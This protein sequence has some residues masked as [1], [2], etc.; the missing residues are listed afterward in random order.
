VVKSY[1]GRGEKTIMEQMICQQLHIDGIDEL[2]DKVYNPTLTKP[3]IA[4]MSLLCFEA[5][6]KGDSVAGKILAQ[7][8]SELAIMAATV[9]QRL[10]MTDKQVDCVFAGSVLK[11]EKIKTAV[12]RELTR[13]CPGIR[14]VIPTQEPVYGAL[15]LGQKIAQGKLI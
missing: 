6:A 9:I 14:V 2:K 1:D 4:E 5:D 15:K 3:E 13:V 11:I 7:A 8:I 10:Q 12:D